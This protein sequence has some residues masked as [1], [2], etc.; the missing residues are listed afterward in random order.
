MRQ[1]I[2]AFVFF[3]LNITSTN[4]QTVKIGVKAGL[5]YANFSGSDIQTDAITTYH[6]GLVAE[7][8]LLD[9]FS[10]QPELLYSTQGASYENAIDEY[11]LYLLD[12]TDWRKLAKVMTR[13]RSTL[14]QY[15]A[16]GG[17]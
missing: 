7:I 15:Y 14:A 9:S 4:A 6:A 3:S 17:K 8:S 11:E 2:I 1:L 16:A 12:E 10:L 5:N 13:L